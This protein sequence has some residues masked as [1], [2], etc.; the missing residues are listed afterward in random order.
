[1]TTN[2][3]RIGAASTTDRGFTLVEVLIV[4]VILGILATVTVFA[5][6]GTTERAADSACLSEKTSIETA[7]DAYLVQQDASMVPADGVGDDRYERSLVSVGILRS[8]SSNWEMDANGVVT[9]Q[10]GGICI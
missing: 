7:H 8:V 9:A 1:M 2:N 4:I 6:Q 3:R 10:A 5:V